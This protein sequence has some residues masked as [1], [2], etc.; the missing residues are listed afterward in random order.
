[1]PSLIL[2]TVTAISSGLLAR[3]Y[4]R[5]RLQSPEDRYMALYGY[6]DWGSNNMD[7]RVHFDPAVDEFVKAGW[8]ERLRL[9]L[10]NPESLLSEVA[11]VG[12]NGKDLV[13]Q[14]LSTTVDDLLKPRQGLWFDLSTPGLIHIIWNHLQVDGVGLWREL[15]EVFDENPP[16]I[17]Y[18]AVAKPPPVLP[19]ILGIPQLAKQATIRGTLYKQMDL[20]KGVEQHFTMWDGAK[21]RMFKD[22]CSVE[23]GQTAPFNL[24]T[25]A[26]V[27]DRIFQRH[28]DAQKLNLGL[29]LYFPFL[30]SRNKYGVQVRTV[31]RDSVQGLVKQLM[32]KQQKPLAAWGTAAAQGY[33]LN[34]V[35]NKWFMNLMSYFRQQIDVLIANVP[36]GQVP[37]SVAGHPV[38]VSCHTREL[39]LPYYVLLMGTRSEVHTSMTTRYQQDQH[40]RMMDLPSSLT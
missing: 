28:P 32:K 16:L 27:A 23:M 35:P 20:E 24:V 3:D 1:M 11:K 18:R 13:F 14:R 17:P 36:V 31:R 15:R 26:L 25:A 38:E 37:V 33:A 12:D 9:R 40:A 22:A 39:S 4:H 8:I 5:R 10:Q 19:E 6:A 2:P 34:R 30:E 21:I 29:T 7:M